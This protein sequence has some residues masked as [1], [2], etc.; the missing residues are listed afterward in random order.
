MSASNDP[1]NKRIS[2][3][4]SAL[5]RRRNIKILIAEDVAAHAELALKEIRRAGLQYE[6]RLV[7]TDGAFRRELRDFAPDIILSD[8]AMPNFDG[9]RALA[10]ARELSPDTP[11]IFVSGMLGEENA[12]RALQ[13]GAVDYVLKGNL[14]RLPAAVERAIA[15]VDRRAAQEDLERELQESEERHR[16]LFQSNPHS[17]W[18]FDLETLRFLDV[19]Q[20]AIVKYGYT[21]DEFLAM[22]IMEIRSPEEVSRLMERLSGQR[23]GLN[24]AGIWQHRTKSGQLLT[25]EIASH[26]IVV[27]GRP[28]KLVVAY[29]VTERQ[30]AARK[31]EESELR[32]RQLIEH[33]ADGIYLSDLD[34]NFVLMNSRGCEMLGYSKEEVVTLNGE[35]TYVDSDKERY[36]DRLAAV[37]GGESLRFER[38]IKRKDGTVFPAEVSLK[39]LE[40]GVI[41]AIFRDISR[42]KHYE[43][44]ILGLTRIHAV[45]SSINSA[46]VRIQDREELFVE[47]CRIATQ[48][49]AFHIAWIGM[50]EQGVLK[51]VAWAGSGSQVFARINEVGSGIELSP[52]GLANRAY[53]A[54]RSVFSNDITDNPN[55]DF[56]RRE[57]VSLGCKSAIALPLMVSEKAIGIFMLY[58]DQEDFFDEE[59]IKLLEDLAGDVSFSLNYIAQREK[60]DFL[61]YYDPLTGLPNRALFIDR[62]TQNLN[63]ASREH[64]NIAL[65]VMNLD[66][67]RAVNETL[68][69]QAGDVLLQAVTTRLRS[70]VRNKDT[71]ARVGSNTFA[72]AFPGMWKAEDLAYAMDFRS[73]EIFDEPFAL[74]GEEL[75]VTA[76]GGI[77]ISPGDGETAEALFANAEAAMR[78]A[79]RQNDRFLFY[80][81]EMNVRVAD[82]LRLE[83][84]LRRA[85]ENGELVLWYQPKIALDSGKLTGFEALMRWEHPQDGLIAPARFI[86]LMEQTGLILEAGNWAMMQAARD[87][88]SWT[89]NG[90]KVPRIAVNASPI[91]LRNK[92]FISMVVE[93]ASRM[94]EAGSAL[95]LEITESVI[96]EDV[97]RIVP[98]LQ[99]IRG[100][101]VEIYI[102]DFGTGY[103]SLAYIARLPIHSLKID[104]SFI[105]G[106]TQNAESLAIVRSVISLAHSLRLHVVA[107]G[108]ETEEQMALLRQLK[109]NQA[110][111]Y[112]LSHPVPVEE[113]A[114]V[115]NR[116]N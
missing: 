2:G 70:V 24:A 88:E 104:R 6:M 68:G 17:M 9:M 69:R 95:D 12:I 25:A 108:V 112:L 96:M 35:V 39:M 47:A 115:L 8:F 13:E 62:L 73:R 38:M 46:I 19:N 79:K 50:V 29:D 66:R 15:E 99:T 5:A 3:P 7:E 65:V 98:I 111:G 40:V 76:A 102:D 61:A 83:N 110:Q 10:I 107:E 82:T 20:A 26:D 74:E 34:G 30:N 57:V 78:N 87:C 33:A 60:A 45:L 93:S 91:Q 80:R 44:K 32:F 28:A 23:T 21:H 37:I 92:G 36:R 22:T 90:L 67:F 116:F 109:C 58:C 89:R 4:Q 51:P 77:A 52:G 97:D 27:K 55:L 101:G 54:Q 94:E 63:G 18:I 81:P 84:Q 1:P 85:L 31:L 105:I 64:E 56:I 42:R 14:L 71:V 16:N 48:H 41:Q 103:S 100:L 114:D 86:P 113:V 11:F 49:G 59:E 72:L 75:R 106:M 53:Q 43:D